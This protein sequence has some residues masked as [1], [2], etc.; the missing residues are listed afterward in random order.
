MGIRLRTWAAALGA[1]AVALGATACGGSGPGTTTGSRGSAEPRAR[2]GAPSGAFTGRPPKALVMVIHGGGWKGLDRKAFEAELPVARGLHALG[3]ASLTVDYRRGAL[4]LTDVEH[5][6]DQARRRVGPHV[7]I[8]AVG[9]SAGGH[10][11]LMLA[12]RR[13]SLTCVIS[14]GGP[15]DLTA[16]R[17]LPRYRASYGLVVRR[18]GRQRLAAFSP[19]LHARSIRASLLLIY[20]SNDPAVPVSQGIE[21]ARAA[22]RAHLIVLPPGPTPFVHSTVDTTRLRAADRQEAAFLARMAATSSG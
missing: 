7:P 21:M 20:A 17:G 2:Y 14:L 5:F 1:L 10:L 11:A 22:P 8:C 18:F 12:V 6:Y 19:A 16:L 3:Y 15:T 13:P 4:G 9:G